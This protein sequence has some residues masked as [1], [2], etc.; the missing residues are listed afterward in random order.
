MARC[1]R[2]QWNLFTEVVEPQLRA[3]AP[4]WLGEATIHVAKRCEGSVSQIVIAHRD[5]IGH[6]ERFSM[7]L[8][9]GHE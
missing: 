4:V 9:G 8:S 2:I 3:G 7:V 6:I 1:S 5:G